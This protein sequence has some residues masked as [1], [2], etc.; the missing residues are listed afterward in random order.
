[1]QIIDHR[2]QKNHSKHLHVSNRIA[3]YYFGRCEVL[4]HLYRLIIKYN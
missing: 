4:G 2:P 3:S 1:L